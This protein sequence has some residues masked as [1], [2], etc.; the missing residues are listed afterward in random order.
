MTETFPG[1]QLQRILSMVIT[2]QRNI[3]DPSAILRDL[4]ARDPTR[5]VD[6]TPSVKNL[7]IYLADNCERLVSYLPRPTEVGSY[8]PAGARADVF[9]K[10]GNAGVL[11]KI[12]TLPQID[13][14]SKVLAS[15]LSRG[16]NQEIRNYIRIVLTERIRGFCSA[17]INAFI[18]ARGITRL[19][20]ELGDISATLLAL[21]GVMPENIGEFAARLDG[22]FDEDHPNTLRSLIEDLRFLASVHPDAGYDLAGWR[23][24]L[25]VGEM[26]QLLMNPED[27]LT[28]EGE[29]RVRGELL[30][31]G[32]LA[33]ILTRRRE[34]GIRRV[35]VNAPK[36]FLIDHNV[37]SPGV[38]FNV[39]SPF[40]KV[41]G[42]KSIDLSGL[43]GINGIDGEDGVS[44]SG[45]EGQV[46]NI[47]GK[48]GD[49]HG[50]GSRFENLSQLTIITNGGAGGRGGN[51]GKSAS[52]F[53]PAERKG[54][55]GGGRGI[56]GVGG[57]PGEIQIAGYAGPIGF[58][59]DL[60][61][62]GVD[63]IPGEHGKVEAIQ[64]KWVYK[65]TY[66]YYAMSDPHYTYPCVVESIPCAPL[67]YHH[68]DNLNHWY[69]QKHPQYDGYERRVI[70]EELDA[71]GRPLGEIIS[72]G[73]WFTVET[74]TET[75]TSVFFPVR[76]KEHSRIKG[77]KW[78]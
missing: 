52:V 18:D 77:G 5:V 72:L 62:N 3:N 9:R 17:R 11:G 6:L 64:E 38:S 71:D 68:T 78:L 1:D 73:E 57:Q 12:V 75:Q 30:G 43:Q 54:Y 58:I 25:P 53:F 59:S 26:R 8:D 69:H 41:I 15:E 70:I 76:A 10:I 74:K 61:R 33:N 23:E 34:Q 27:V 45:L 50:V 60:G 37:T 2:K 28:S 29:L 42:V 67:T 40:W 16:L 32:D 66:V 4:S 22:F 31:T 35:T 14:D 13:A 63:G 56:G 19:R 47:G 21:Q 65:G 48:G 24:S 39:E 49:F 36:A 46:G 20:E 7:L 51:G 44:G 55:A